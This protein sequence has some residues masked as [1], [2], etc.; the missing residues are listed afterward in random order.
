[1][2]VKEAIEAR[3]AYRSLEPVEI[4]EEIITE[5]GKAAQLAMSCFN[6]QPWRFV[7]V[8]DADML[9]RM[10]EALSSGNKWA[11]RASMIIA[12]TSRRDLDCAPATREYYAFDSGMATAFLVLRATELGLVAHPIA[13]YSSKKTRIILGIPDDVD[14]LALVIVGKKD[15]R[16][17]ELLSADQAER[18]RT[19]PARLA[20]EHIVY[21]NRFDAGKFHER[22]NE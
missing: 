8:Y 16:V 2:N 19:R 10:Q 13:G 20:L 5:L 7:F 21:R 9:A 18:E 14:V 15:P 22:E 17:N 1:M 3:R 11:Q 6:N 4:T 12:V